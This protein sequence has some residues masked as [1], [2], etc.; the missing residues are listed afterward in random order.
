MTSCLAHVVPRREACVRAGVTKRSR[1]LGRKP[2]AP[3]L[4][5]ASTLDPPVGD[6][7]VDAG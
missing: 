6:V 3:P 4:T 2:P 1:V 7:G 5:A